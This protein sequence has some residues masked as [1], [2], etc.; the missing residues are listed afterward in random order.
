MGSVKA[1]TRKAVRARRLDRCS[2]V[3]CPDDKSCDTSTTFLLHART[4]VALQSRKARLFADSF[5][6][7]WKALKLRRFKSSGGNLKSLGVGAL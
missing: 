5:A 6:I 7:D 2:A 4:K 3:P 1:T